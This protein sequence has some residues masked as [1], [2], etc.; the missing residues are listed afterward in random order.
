MF[1]LDTPVA[2]SG[3]GLRSEVTAHGPILSIARMVFCHSC[4]IPRSIVEMAFSSKPAKMTACDRSLRY[5]SRAT[6]LACVSEVMTCAHTTRAGGAVPPQSGKPDMPL[7][8]S[9]SASSAASIKCGTLPDGVVSTRCCEVAEAQTPEVEVA[10]ENGM[11]LRQAVESHL[12]R[13]PLADARWKRKPGHPAN[14][15]WVSWFFAAA[16][17]VVGDPVCCG[18]RS[19]TWK[20]EVVRR[21]F[22]RG[23]C[24]GVGHAAVGPPWPV[25]TR[26]ASGARQSP[27]LRHTSGVSKSDPPR[28]LRK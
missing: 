21:D 22:P 8:A 3:D 12:A 18:W 26:P 6:S 15:L 27:L 7:A 20:T 10:Q 16:A 13:M 23:G 17:V 1:F 2:C 25:A 24:V 4:S 9:P 28:P 11:I 5:R 19:P 14:E